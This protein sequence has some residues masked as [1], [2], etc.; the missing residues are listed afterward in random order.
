MGLWKS[1]MNYLRTEKEELRKLAEDSRIDVLRFNDE[2]MR[3]EIE[4]NVYI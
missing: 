4:R 1:W 2:R 3:E